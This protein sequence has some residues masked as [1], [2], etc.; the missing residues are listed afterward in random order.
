M[1]FDLLHISLDLEKGFEIAFGWPLVII[2]MIGILYFGYRVWRHHRH[3]WKSVEVEISLGKIGKVKIVPNHE[4]I[5]I[6]HQAWT[7]LTTRKAGLIFDERHDVIIEVYDSWYALFKELRAL[8]KTVPAEQL[9]QSE[10]AKQLVNILVKA[11]NDGLRPHLTEWQAKYRRWYLSEEKKDSNESK[12]PQAIQMTYPEYDSLIESLKL[13][14]R[15]MIEFT[16]ALKTI[17][18]GEN[19]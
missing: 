8:T 11:M 13:V 4:V 9:R 18:Q 15:Q 1:K 14:N 7:E 19:T 6:A 2:S 5:R 10:D 12:T 16:T 17:A 3:S